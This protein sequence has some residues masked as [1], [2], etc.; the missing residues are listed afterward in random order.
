MFD[1]NLIIFIQIEKSFVEMLTS[2][3]IAF[4]SFLDLS[5]VVHFIFL[6]SLPSD[7]H[8]AIDAEAYDGNNGAAKD[9][10]PE[11]SVASGHT[12]VLWDRWTARFAYDYDVWIALVIYINGIFI[13]WAD[14]F[15]YF[16]ADDCRFKRV[17]WEEAFTSDT[18]LLRTPSNIHS[19]AYT[20]IV[21]HIACSCW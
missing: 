9:H 5:L 12:T 17:R 11:E 7:F 18:L 15:K 13:V 16:I 19:L 1:T 21:K 6:S 8:E 10:K 4:C 2:V 20:F 14:C 3:F